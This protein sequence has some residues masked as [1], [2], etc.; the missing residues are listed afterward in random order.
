MDP[1]DFQILARK[2]ACCESPAKAEC[3]SSIS[4]AYYAAY[5][6]GA[7]IL[8]CLGIPVSTGPEGHSEVVRNLNYSND[9]QLKKVGSQLNDLRSDRNK[10]DYRLSE[11]KIETQEKAKAAVSQASRMIQ[12]LDECKKGESERRK[13]AAESIKEYLAKIK[14]RPVSPT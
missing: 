11:K 3:R 6:V 2:L 1:R 9:K 4:R 13:K 14:A 5:H 7:E 10:A 8:N 12:I